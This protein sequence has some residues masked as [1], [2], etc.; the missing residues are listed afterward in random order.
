MSALPDGWGNCAIYMGV[1]VAAGKT[2]PA[3]QTETACITDRNFAPASVDGWVTDVK[4]FG[5]MYVKCRTL[6]AFISIPYCCHI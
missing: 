3:P 5:L 6:Q 2:T 1:N 4:S